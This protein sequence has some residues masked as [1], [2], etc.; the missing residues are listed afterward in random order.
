MDKVTPRDGINRKRRVCDIF[1]KTQI[2]HITKHRKFCGRRKCELVRGVYLNECFDCHGFEEDN[3]YHV[4]YIIGKRVQEHHDR[5]LVQNN[6]PSRNLSCDMD[7]EVETT[8]SLI[9]GHNLKYVRDVVDKATQL[10][11]RKKYS[12][13]QD[14]SRGHRVDQIATL[15]MAGCADIKS[16]DMHGREYIMNNRELAISCMSMMESIQQRIEK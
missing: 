13:L 15:I 12:D 5:S 2:Q 10:N 11:Y 16:L 14:R 1:V 7:V 6:N 3:T 4:C 9:Q 8:P